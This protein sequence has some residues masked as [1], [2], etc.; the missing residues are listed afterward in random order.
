VHAQFHQAD[1]DGDGTISKPE[2]LEVLSQQMG[3]EAA[4]MQIDH[5]FAAI[6]Q[7]KSGEITLRELAVWYFGMEAKQRAKHTLIKLKH[8]KEE[9]KKNRGKVNAVTNV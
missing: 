4:H 2:L 7:D 5:V 9:E 3:E 8:R 6:D 1:R